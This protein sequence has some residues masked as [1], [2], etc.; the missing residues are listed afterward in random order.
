M[1]SLANMTLSN[2]TTD[3]IIE[4]D[5]VRRLSLGPA[6]PTRVREIIAKSLT[7]TALSADE[8]AEL[9]RA[10]SPELI[11]EIFAAARAQQ[12]A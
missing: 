2:R 11:E 9:V 4:D 10:D 5:L 8:T 3:F 7:K 1:G 6:D 12:A